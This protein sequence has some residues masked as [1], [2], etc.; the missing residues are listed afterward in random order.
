MVHLGVD[1]WDVSAMFARMPPLIPPRGKIRVECLMLM[2]PFLTAFE[3]EGYRIEPGP[4]DTHWEWRERFPNLQRLV[5]RGGLD[6]A[7][8]VAAD[9]H[10]GQPPAPLEDFRV[11]AARREL[12][13]LRGLWPQGEAD[14]AAAVHG[15]RAA[16]IPDG[17]SIPAWF[18][19]LDAEAAEYL[20]TTGYQ[21]PAA[22]NPAY[23]AHDIRA[24]W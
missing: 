23:P 7:G 12:D 16:G 11:A 5:A 14:W 9:L 18:E 1:H 22:P 19:R 3:N 20:E 21:P 4:P 15:L 17:T 8:A 13:E 10:S 6:P 2:V 24:L